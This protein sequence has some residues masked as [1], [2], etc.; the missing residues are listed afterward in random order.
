MTRRAEKS[1]EAPRY[2]AAYRRRPRSKRTLL[3]NY[4]T[5]SESSINNSLSTHTI[6]SSATLQTQQN[7]IFP[8]TTSSHGSFPTHPPHIIPASAR[9]LNILSS[10]RRW[11]TEPLRATCCTAQTPEGGTRDLRRAP[12]TIDRRIQHASNAT[13]G[14]P[15]SQLCPSIRGC[16]RSTDRRIW[17]WRRATSELADGCPTRIR[18]REEPQDRRDWRT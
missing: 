3:L 18:G 12:K 15:V 14:Q 4:N 5:C 6:F 17:R 1:G 9:S 11:Q 7:G 2:R 13:K 16:T 8:I 10:P